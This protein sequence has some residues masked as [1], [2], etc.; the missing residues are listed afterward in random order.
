[1]SD[2]TPKVDATTEDNTQENTTPTEDN[3]QENA[4]PTNPWENTF[5]G[6]TPKKS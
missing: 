4:T 5:P 2:N 3:T 1:M 6:K